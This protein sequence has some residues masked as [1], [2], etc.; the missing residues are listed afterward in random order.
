[1]SIFNL[2]P[3]IDYNVSDYDLIGAIDI[4]TSLRIKSIIKNY[5]L[6]A[7]V[8]YIVSDGER[9]DQVSTN[10]Y[11]NPNYDWI[12]LM[13][14]DVYSIYDEWPKSSAVLERYIRTKYGSILKA[15]E[16]VKYYNTNGDIIDFTTYNSLSSSE[17]S[18]ITI[19]SDYERELRMN[20]NKSKIKVLRP[21]FISK[22]DSDLKS[23]INLLIE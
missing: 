11:G 18:A 3:K 22:I 16:V 6:I 15:Q 7:S 9:P 1:M 21:N 12:I 10:V 14:N 2:Y 8:P 17:K 19:E 4:T 23:S 5:S 20:V 13:T